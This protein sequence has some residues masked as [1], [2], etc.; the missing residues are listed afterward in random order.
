MCKFGEAPLSRGRWRYFF[1]DRP[2]VFG[3]DVPRGARTHKVT[4]S[5]FRWCGASVW[6]RGP[7]ATNTDKLISGV[8]MGSSSREENGDEKFDKG[9]AESLGR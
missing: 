1:R 5:S 8:R 9:A 4:S 2:D 6:L 3:S 7:V